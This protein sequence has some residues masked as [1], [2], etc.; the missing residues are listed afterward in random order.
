MDQKIKGLIGIAGN[1]FVGK[2]TFC[3]ALTEVFEK[4]Y[5]LKSVR[6]SI[7]GDKIRRNLKYISENHFNINIENP[8][9][10]QKKLIRPFM[11]EYGIVMRKLTKGRY[12][13]EN[14]QDSDIID[15][16]PD[17]RYCEYS[18]DED[19]WL[20]EE[21]NGFL[22]FLE[23][24]NILPANKYEEKNNQILK[25]KA[26]L[27]LNLPTFKD[28]IKEEI[29]KYADKAIKSFLIFKNDYHFPTGHF[30]AFK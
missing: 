8:S 5:G 14:F 22:I 2:D 25:T 23:R 18:K 3:K 19:Y 6:R 21:K 17:I 9:I 27:S 12:F 16:I 7:A 24:E 13:I 11:V 4:N 10:D 15:I 1:G 28:N 29:S 30:S 20:K 26:N